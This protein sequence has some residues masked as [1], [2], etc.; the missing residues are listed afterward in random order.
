MVSTVQSFMTLQRL[1]GSLKRIGLLERQHFV[2][3]GFDVFISSDPT[4]YMSFAMP[5]TNLED[6]GAAILELQSVFGS[7]QRR[8]RLEYFHELYPNLRAALEQA[9]FMLD[10][11]APVMVIEPQQLVVASGGWVR[12]LQPD[13]LEIERFLR[14]QSVAFGGTS[15]DDSLGWLESIL[16]GLK[17]GAARG[18]WLEVNNQMVSGAIIQ[19]AED[20]ELAGVWTAPEHQGKG[21]AFAVCHALLEGYFASGQSLCWLSAAVGAQQLYTKLGFQVVGTQLNM[22]LG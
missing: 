13:K 1:E 19:G 9:K 17:S 2:T 8:V 20:G 3:T 4:E 7:H 22:R 14:G 21:F 18:M 10:M 11:S 15:G 16:V 5:H 12:V 6:W